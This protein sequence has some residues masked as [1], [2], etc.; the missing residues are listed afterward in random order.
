[1]SDS[2][3][4]PSIRKLAIRGTIWTIASYGISNVLRFA[5]NLILTYLLAPRLFGLMAL[6]N[7]FVIGLHLFSDIGIGPSIIQSR[8]GD[9]PEFLNTAWTL[10]VIRGFQIWIVCLLLAV[11]VAQFYDERD[12]VWLLPIVGLTT[13]INGFGSTSLFTLNRH[14]SVKQLAFYELGGQIVGIVVMV[15]WAWFDRSIWALV[16]GGLVSSLIQ[17]VWSHRIVAG[18][19]NRFCWERSAVLEIIAFGKWIFVSTALTFLATQSDRMVLGKLFTLDLLGVY[20][21]AF[22]LADIPRQIVMAVSGKVIFPTFAKFAE[23]PRQEFRQKIH[24]NRRLM[25]IVTAVG[26]AITVSFGDLIVRIYRAEYGQAAWMLPIL[27]FGVWPAILNATLGPALLA[28]GNP[29]YSTYA[30]F[31]GAVFL[32]GGIMLGF[33]LAGPVGAVFAISFSSLP[34]YLATTYGLLREE[35]SCLR[36]DGKSTILF[37]GITIVLIS[38]RT[39]A[40]FPLPIPGSG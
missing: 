9:D 11:P 22:S 20:G 28:I 39:M 24:R 25:L 15:T 6:V 40:G 32:I 5:S 23:L 19:Q 33:H 4:S 35:L 8:R 29:R 10:Q 36:Q 14:L 1:M 7:T 17:L 2:T 38:C 37:L 3:A 13:V 30:S 18:V 12:L 16:M 31:W 34:A 26:L 21:I 27:A